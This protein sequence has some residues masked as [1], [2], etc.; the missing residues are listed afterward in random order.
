MV[1]QW[2]LI[3]L[4]A[5]LGSALGGFC[6]YLL[7]GAV[8]RRFG[9]RFP[10]G[11]L[12]VNVSGAFLIGLLWNAHW[13]QQTFP[14]P[15]MQ[16]LLLIGFLGGYTTVSSFT[17]NTMNLWQQGEWGA[18]GSNVLLSFSLC[19]FAVFAGSALAPW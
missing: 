14:G 15:E 10:M 9:E 1:I 4:L 3:A 5:F 8:A 7:S 11:T 12:A 13:L 2:S 18:A 17:L 6:R 19:L 16:A